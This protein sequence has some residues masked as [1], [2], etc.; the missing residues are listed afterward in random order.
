[1]SPCIYENTDTLLPRHLKEE[2]WGLKLL[3]QNQNKTPKKTQQ[4]KNPHPTNNIKTQNKQP[5]QRKAVAKANMC[6]LFAL[7][8]ETSSILDRKRKS[9][10]FMTYHNSRGNGLKK[11]EQ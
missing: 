6:R 1:M 3:E 11:C 9:Q 5:N 10:V 8:G 4:Q 2:C 7:G